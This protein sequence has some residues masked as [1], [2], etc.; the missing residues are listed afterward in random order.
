M[1][2]GSNTALRDNGLVDSRLHAVF[3]FSIGV[4]YLVAGCFSLLRNARPASDDTEGRLLR[5]LRVKVLFF[6]GR[7]AFEPVQP[8]ANLFR[9]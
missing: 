8:C 2:Y 7:F 5:S 6:L 9:V 1:R 3:D 4:G